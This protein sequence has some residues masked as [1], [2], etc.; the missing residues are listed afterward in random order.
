MTVDETHA[1]TPLLP[2]GEPL[3][4]GHIFEDL[5]PDLF[6]WVGENI[7]GLLMTMAVYFATIML[8]TVGGLVT[9]FFLLAGG[10]LASAGVV[11]AVEQF[12]SGET[13]ALTSVGLIL[14]G[15]TLYVV[16]MMFVSACL[17]LFP[18]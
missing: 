10:T 5:I 3:S 17:S 11:V 15:Y 2:S 9:F 1:S 8:V 7:R 13:S 4:I 14:V 12:T 16:F 6:T 18:H